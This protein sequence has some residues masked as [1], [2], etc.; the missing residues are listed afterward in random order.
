VLKYFVVWYADLAE[1]LRFKNDF[2]CWL[3]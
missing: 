2:C 1:S 3:L